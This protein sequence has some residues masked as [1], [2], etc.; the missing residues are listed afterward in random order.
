M[1]AL[2]RFG[3]G[4]LGLPAWGGRTGEEPAIGIVSAMP[5]FEQVPR[6]PANFTGTLM[7]WPLEQ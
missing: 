1:T 4:R 3:C 2:C 5:H 6:L 7:R